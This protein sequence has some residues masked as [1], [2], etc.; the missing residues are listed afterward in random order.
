M[1]ALAGVSRAQGGLWL[2]H[3][4]KFRGQFGRCH[5]AIDDWMHAVADGPVYGSFRCVSG[6]LDLRSMQ[7][8]NHSVCWHITT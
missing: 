8:V 3:G 5:H 2:V 7:S 4:W 1:S 6:T